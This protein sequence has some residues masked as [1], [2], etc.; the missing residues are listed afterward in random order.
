M[1]ASN[2]IFGAI[3]SHFAKLEENY[4]INVIGTI[5]PG[6]PSPEMPPLYIITDI[7]GD[8]IIIAIIGYTM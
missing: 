3:I 6:L 5:N 2:V 1:N 8:C 4:K 7:I